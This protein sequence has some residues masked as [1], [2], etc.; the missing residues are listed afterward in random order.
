MNFRITHINLTM[1]SNLKNSKDRAFTRIELVAIIAILALLTLILLPA[2]AQDSQNSTR[3]QCVN[4][5]KQVELAFKTWAV[6]NGDKY[7]MS[8]STKLG[9]T[10]EFAKDGNVFRHFQVMSN[11][12]STPKL[13]ICPSDTRTFAANFADLHNENISYFV[14]LDAND[15]NPQMFLSGDRNIENGKSPIHSVLE[16]RPEIPAR[17]TET[18]HNNQ[19]NVGLA[20]GSVLQFTS[21]RLQQALQKTGDST[22]RIALPE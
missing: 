7:P 1:N 5:L 3:R 14:G 10:K 2:L 18:I 9:G 11:E 4:N 15:T 6:D 12:L 13:L 19:G 8:V 20:D 16:L 22:N 17:W 21:A